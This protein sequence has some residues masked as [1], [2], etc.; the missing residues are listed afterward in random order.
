MVRSFPVPKPTDALSLNSNLFS[1]ASH[2]T[3]DTPA[4]PS[5]SISPWNVDIPSTLNAPALLFA[6]PTVAIPEM[7]ISVAPIPPLFHSPPPTCSL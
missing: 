6:T 7:V 4:E 5:K 2:K 3:V 1:D